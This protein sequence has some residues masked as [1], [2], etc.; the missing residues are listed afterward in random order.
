[1]VYLKAIESHG[2]KSFADKVTIQFDRGITGVVGPNGSGKS[3]ITDAIRWVL[4]EQ[5]AKTMRGSTMQDVIF[6]GS[7]TRKPL[8]SAYVKLILSN[9]TRSLK[10][11]R[12]EVHIERK[13]FR[14]GDSEYYLNNEKCRLKDITELFMDSGLGKSAYNIISQGEVDQVLKAKPEER[15]HLIE[16][17]AGVMKYKSRKK[18]SE[19]KLDDTIENLSRLNDIITELS[20]QREQMSRERDIALEYKA[21]YEAMAESDIEVTVHDIEQLANQLYATDKE[22]EAFERDLNK[23]E[24]EIDRINAEMNLLDEESEHLNDTRT[25]MQSALVE[26]SRRA[27]QLSGNIKLYKERK[28]NQSKASE[29]LHKEQYRIDTQ[30]E[31]TSSQILELK[32]E[33]SRL[34]QQLEQ[35]KNE[36]KDVV[37]ERDVYLENDSSEIESLRDAFFELSVQKTTAENDLKERARQHEKR[38]NYLKDRKERLEAAE[39]SLDEVETKISEIQSEYEELLT[40]QEVL[41]QE[42][43][44]KYQQLTVK[45]SALKESETRVDRGERYLAN[46]VSRLDILNTLIDEYKGFYP[47]VRAVLKARDTLKGIHGAVG[48]LFTVPAKYVTAFDTA[49]GASSQNI[50]VQSESSA[51]SAINFL[52]DKKSGFATFLPLDTVQ[53]RHINDSIKRNIEASNIDTWVLRDLVEYDAIFTAVANHLFCTT[54]VCRT[55]DDAAQLA[56]ALNYRVKIVT[57]QGETLMPGGAVSGGSKARNTSVVEMKNEADTLSETVARYR[58][59]LRVFIKERDEH[60]KSYKALEKEYQSADARL[61]ALEDELEDLKQTRVSLDMRKENLIDTIQSL[62]Y[63]LGGSETDDTDVVDIASIDKEL[64]AIR[65]RIHMLSASDE[66]KKEKI[67]ALNDRQNI[68]ARERDKV[69]IHL[70]NKITNLKEAEI[71][72]A[73][74]NTAR[75]D[76]AAQIFLLSEDLSKV[77]IEAFEREKLKK[78]EEITRLE[79]SIED[80]KNK[81]AELRDNQRTYNNQ[82]NLAAESIN[83]LNQK[84]RAATGQREKVDTQLEA[85]VSYLETEY[86]TTFEKERPRFDTFADIE[87]KRRMVRLNKRS[88]DELGPVNLNSIEAYDAVNERYTFLKSQETDLLEAHA[89]LKEIIRDMDMEVSTRFKEVYE[90]VNAHFQD[91]FREM[92]GGGRAELRLTIPDDYLESGIEI[93]AEPPGKRLSS[94]SLLSGGERALTTISLLF[95]ILKVRISPFVILDEVEAA[96]DEANVLRFSRYLRTLSK[97]T[98]FIVITHRKGTMEYSDRLFGLTMAEQGVTSIISVDLNN[99]ERVIGEN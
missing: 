90:Q 78:E 76:N 63:D 22:I 71:V 18:E 96:L 3:N 70:N 84:L 62:E 68:I 73:D 33:K 88:I 13:L 39:T 2:F 65:T 16:E 64:E 44:D 4:G 67:E 28:E 60:A 14:N 24:D 36:E 89:T 50:V 53:P 12:D 49:L 57:L 7:D 25:S 20:Q 93:L 69:T 29:N 41:K 10:L 47:G 21:L 51:K 83:E 66:E 1:M 5:S 98:Q 95:S 27:E 85:R 54:L 17:A 32:N 19:S 34:Q 87:E 23:N 92:F 72:L 31:E 40:E 42:V 75:E 80:N 59:E 48:E 11:E 9:V 6:S 97:D 94:L 77:D 8:N 99:Y 56:K 45:F 61:N 37:K 81:L 26:A 74:L 52:K 86:K 55:I 82:K 58:H 43:K 46:E 38:D 91:V 35:L 15:R 79:S 30:I